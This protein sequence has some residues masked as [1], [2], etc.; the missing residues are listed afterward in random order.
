MDSVVAPDLMT[1][2]ARRA[3]ARLRAWARHAAT[4][5]SAGSMVLGAVLGAAAFVFALASPSAPVSASTPATVRAPE[6][7]GRLTDISAPVTPAPAMV[8]PDML[9]PI[10]AP[11]PAAIETALDYDVVFFWPAR[12]QTVAEPVAIRDGPAS[13]ARVLRS[14][15]PGERLRINGRVE[16]APNGPWLRVRLADGQDGY[17]AARTVDVGAFRQRR[18]TEAAQVAEAGAVS[19][20]AAGAPLMSSPDDYSDP[21]IGPPSF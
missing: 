12:P 20:E 7:R 19:V 2:F 1:E 18:A 16:D 6:I 11:P 10:G 14:A 5:G 17:F 21:E 8:A 9:A 4:F 3:I 13:Y 15:R